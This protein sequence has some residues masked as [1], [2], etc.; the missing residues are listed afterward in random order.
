M[1]IDN[2]IDAF[3]K[4]HPDDENLPKELALISAKL[5]LPGIVG[6]AIDAVRGRLGKEVQVERAQD[7]LD[8]LENELR[9]IK[10]T[11]A[12]KQDL[13]DLKESL[14]LAIRNDVWEFNDKKRERYVRIVGNA[15]RGETRI[16]D[17][18]SFIQ[19]V[20]Q[21]GER[22]F[23]ALKVL[24]NVM[25]KNGDWGANLSGNIHPGLFI[26]RRQELAARMAEAFGADSSNPKFSRE[27]GYEACTR[28]QGF[29][30]AH[31]IELS[32]REVPVGEYCFRPSKRGLSLL[33][34]V[35][36][37][38]PNWNNYFSRTK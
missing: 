25:N 26:Q 38:V 11:T 24:N 28:L 17:L 29:G 33:K 35:G 3:K 36:E 5:V 32:P 27:E 23:V 8:L 19:D 12:S 30:L 16:E 14:Q 7:M 15:L 10:D 18:A 22:D 4:A 34:L 1:A 6:A 37:E 20:E 13:S 21:L 31:E 2:R 9:D